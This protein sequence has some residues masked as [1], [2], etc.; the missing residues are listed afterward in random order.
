M[1]SCGRPISLVTTYIAAALAFLSL[2]GCDP[3][4]A[5]HVLKEIQYRLQTNNIERSSFGEIAERQLVSTRRFPFFM[6]SASSG[7]NTNW[8]RF[9]SCT[10]RASQA[11]LDHSGVRSRARASPASTDR[12]APAR[13]APTQANASTSRR[14]RPGSMLKDAS[15]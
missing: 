5:N 14:R 7:K 12:S 3:L 8:E 13:S 2:V 4:C 9:R 6:K 1:I 15:V 11:A 10:M